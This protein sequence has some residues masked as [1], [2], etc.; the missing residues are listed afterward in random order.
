MNR[1]YGVSLPSSANLEPLHLHNKIEIKILANTLQGKKSRYL[2]KYLSWIL[3]CILP[4][5]PCL[6]CP[7]P[8][9]PFCCFFLSHFLQCHRTVAHCNPHSAALH[10]GCKEPP[11]RS[12]AKS[13]F[14]PTTTTVPLVPEKNNPK[15]Y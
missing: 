13:R 6:F 11:H 10:C 12:N 4:N 9:R 3:S 2:A 15:L 8:R 5:T 1:L 14:T 7:S